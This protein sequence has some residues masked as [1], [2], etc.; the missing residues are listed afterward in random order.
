MSG[1]WLN[2][3]IG[4]SVL[5]KSSRRDLQKFKSRKLSALK[6]LTLSNLVLSTK[7]SLSKTLTSFA[8][9][10]LNR[11]IG[12]LFLKLGIAWWGEKRSMTMR[13]FI[14]ALGRHS[15]KEKVTLDDLFFYIAWMEESVSMSLGMWL[16]CRCVVLKDVGSTNV[17]RTVLTPLAAVEYRSSI[18]FRCWQY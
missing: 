13:Q 6:G 7:E 12:A 2:S 10:V 11:M 4:T 14:Q 16:M 9:L 15:G 5:T 1:E 17:T 18:N 3:T 8:M